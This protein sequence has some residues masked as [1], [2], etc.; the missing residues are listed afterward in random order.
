MKKCAQNP[1][2]PQSKLNLSAMWH[3]Y[4]SC[5]AEIAEISLTGHQG[6]KESAGG[7]QGR[8][9]R[10]G[11]VEEIFHFHWKVKVTLTLSLLMLL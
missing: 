4:L 6:T 9:R 11:A 8:R 3:R 1:Q 5:G 7:A 2:I 10:E